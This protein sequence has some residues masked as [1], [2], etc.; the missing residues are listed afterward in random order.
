[1]NC[2]CKGKVKKYVYE[3]E[4]TKKHNTTSKMCKIITS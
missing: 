4:N 1:M 3:I 2:L